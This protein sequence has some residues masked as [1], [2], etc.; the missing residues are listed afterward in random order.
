MLNLNIQAVEIRQ[1][2]LEGRAKEF[3]FAN[4]EQRDFSFKHS[5]LRN[6]C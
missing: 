5:V 6:R 2:E 1:P 3:F 4:P